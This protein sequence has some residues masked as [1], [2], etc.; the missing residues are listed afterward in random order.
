VKINKLIKN[1]DTAISHSKEDIKYIVDSYTA[2]NISDSQMTKWLKAVY[3]KGMDF[4]ETINYTNTVVNSGKKIKFKNK[5]GFFIDKHSTGGVGDKVS[6]ILGPILAACGC[7]VPMIVGRSLGHTGGTLDKLESIPGYNGLLTVN[8]FKDI[9]NRV[10]ISII[11]QTDEICP[12]DKKIYNLRSETDTIDSFPLI[13]GSIMGKK[14]AEGIEGLVLDIKTGNGAFMN[15]KK[16]ALGLG[17]FLKKIGE[18][19]NINVK[20]AITDM[21][22]PLGNYSGL[23][24]EIIESMETLKDNG[25]EDLLKVVYY[26]GD[27][28]LKMAGIENTKEKINEV[29]ADGS[30]YEILCKMIYAHGGLRKQIQFIPEKVKYIKSKREGFINYIDTK[31]L[32]LCVNALTKENK[33]ITDTHGGIKMIKKNGLYVKKND[34]IAKI[35]CSNK[36]KLNSAKKIFENSVIIEDEKIN[37]NKLIVH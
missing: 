4:Q 12:A 27:I 11:G 30:A 10:G 6:I 1:K 34:I 20:F 18:E 31:Q 24:C 25:P 8:K 21:N 35:F 36:D 17:K 2:G 23:L 3:S 26:L 28:S 22:Q 32:G 29:I 19:F 13:C 14:I 16:K 7:Y 5:K 37:P 15:T 33:I 9:V